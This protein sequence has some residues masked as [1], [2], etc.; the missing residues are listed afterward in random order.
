MTRHESGT[1]DESDGD[2]SASDDG[3]GGGVLDRFTPDSVK[4]DSLLA[5]RRTLLRGTVAGVAT[6]LAGCSL[7]FGDRE[8]EAAPVRLED[9]ADE[10]GYGFIGAD[11]PV[12]R[13]SV[14]IGGEERE[15]TLRS[16]YASYEHGSGVAVGLVSTPAV[17]EAGQSLNPIARTPLGELLT[18]EVG[19]GFLA[20]LKVEA[21]FARGPDPVGGGEGRLLDSSTEFTTFAGVI[22]DGSFV[23]VN[24]ARTEH[25]GDAVLVG[26]AWR[27]DVDESDRAYVA[28]DGYVSQSM[29]DG[30][31]EDFAA[32]LPLV[33][34]GE[35]PPGTTQP[36]QDRAPEPLVD[37]P[38]DDE[39]WQV[40]GGQMSAARIDGEPT[41]I[42]EDLRDA[43]EAA[44]TPGLAMVFEF[45]IAENHKIAG[46]FETA[47]D[48][49]D[50]VLDGHDEL[51]FLEMP[52]REAILRK[53]A[54]AEE[55]LGRIDD[56]MAT[57]DELVDA[58][59]G[60]AA[61]PY[62]RKGLA[63]ERAG[64]TDGAI[65]AYENAAE[66]E[67]PQGHHLFGLDE[68]GRR[69]AERVRA[70]FDGFYD[71]EA[72]LRERL[73]A[74][75]EDGAYDELYE[76]ASPTHFTA[77]P[78]GGCKGFVA[79]EAF[80]DR[81]V[82]DAEQS[83]VEV[84]AEGVTENETT[85]YLHTENWDGDL[86]EGEVHFE[87]SE[88][89]QGWS[90]EGLAVWTPG[91]IEYLNE[92]PE[93]WGYTSP[94]EV[95]GDLTPTD[96][97]TPEPTDSPS[98]EPT[99]SPEPTPVSS[100]YP[101]IDIAAP[102]KSGQQFRAGGY[103]MGSGGGCGIGIAGYYYDQGPTHVASNA[104]SKHAIDFSIPGNRAFGHH[105]LATN[106][107][108]VGE[109]VEKCK[110]GSN[111][112]ANKVGVKHFA[113]HRCGVFTDFWSRY[114][115]LAGK[116][117]VPVSKGQPVKQGSRLGYMD[118]SGVSVIHHLHFKIRNLH[119][120]DSI[121]P[122]PMDGQSLTASDA[123][124]CITSKNVETVVLSSYSHSTP[125]C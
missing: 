122:T 48:R 103:P 91:A 63:A 1:G 100:K 108:V 76:L 31:I 86:F 39:A 9:S 36:S 13:R 40:L 118:N 112:A 14:E 7:I 110:N 106:D 37:D 101:T 47:I 30:T 55:E 124:K 16:H 43:A 84:D 18:T 72:P 121:M 33:V 96:S 25:D 52:F 28:A 54:T 79:V 89:P 78:A 65:R 41:R 114:L 104:H 119:T 32:L 12:L 2:G 15:V 70:P 123:G 21:D 61:R 57:Y 26:M 46:E 88:S 113:E 83:A 80:L 66:A 20:Q 56:A 44:S 87:L 68:M 27:T 42:N 117:K 24:V 3:D 73:A 11:T 92:N 109:V 94:G 64:M 17:S 23:L 85:V 97:P 77:G 105:V 111:N 38:A 120:G 107:G 98:P 19:E 53:R 35:E 125:S 59:G 62:Y 69:A 95:L 45:W 67:D 60:T 74:V 99:A 116:Y 8:Y 71:A 22:N 90:W 81:L 29:V 49:Y 5:D 10:R 50:A 51:V 82:E 34:H 6:G 102:F 75:I 115:H 93:L 4:G 58:T